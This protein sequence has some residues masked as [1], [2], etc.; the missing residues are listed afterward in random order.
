MEL[1]DVRRLLTDPNRPGSLANRTRLQ[2]RERILATFPEIERMSV[3]DVGGTAD[4]WLHLAIR[5]TD[6]TL[7]NVADYGAPGFRMVI[8]DAC[9]PPAEVRSRRY[10]LVISNSVI[11]QVGGAARRRQLADVI[12]ELAPH[13]WVQTANRRFVLDAYFLF[14]GFAL[15]PVELRVAVLRR[16]PLTH[17]HTKDPEEA[18]RRVLSVELQTAPDLRALFPGTR[19]IVERFLGMPKSLIAT[20]G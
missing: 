13:Y 17:L 3:L 14:P 16:W 19:I 18:L 5:P 20:N 2:R 8:G 4:F 12:L 1:L 7:L 11:D 15:L 9:D 6:L 10:D